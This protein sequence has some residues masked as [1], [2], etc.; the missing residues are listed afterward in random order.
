MK[1][2]MLITGLVVLAAVGTGALL[3]REP[4]RLYR[5]Q[6]A[7]T[8]QSLRAMRAAEDKSANLTRQKAHADSPLGREELAR[9][10]GFRKPGEALV[11]AGER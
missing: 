9:K 8:D 11:D 10:M 7:K 2:R 6:Q 3:S 4:W 5:E 1:A